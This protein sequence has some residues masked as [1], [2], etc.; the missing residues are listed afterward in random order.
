MGKELDLRKLTDVEVYNA[1]ILPNRPHGVFQT[2]KQYIPLNRAVQRLGGVKKLHQLINRNFNHGGTS[3]MFGANPVFTSGPGMDPDAQA[4]ID[5]MTAP[6]ALEQSSIN[7]FVLAEKASGNWSL[8]DEFYCHSLGSTNGVIG[9]R[10]KIATINGGVTWSINGAT[11]NSTT[12]YLGSGYNPT[13]DA[14]NLTLEDGIITQFVKTVPKDSSFTFGATTATPNRTVIRK[15]DATTIQHGLSVNFFGSIETW[16]ADMLVAISH[17]SG[18]ELLHMDGVLEDTDVIAATG[19]PNQEYL[20]G[21]YFNGTPCC[22]T[23]ATISTTLIGA[24]SGFDH[25]AHNTNV[26]SLLTNLGV[27]L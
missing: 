25:V 16:R 1:T 13:T 18:A 8:Y 27:T 17:V 9:S 7:T 5:R 26:R 15:F 10:A 23:D 24:G 4:W 12:G 19:L 6:T 3:K 21:A 2:G 22:F 20:I 14:T 11:F